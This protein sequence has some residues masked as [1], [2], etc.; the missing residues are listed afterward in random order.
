[1]P[2]FIASNAIS[3]FA[4]F[5]VVGYLRGRTA[6]KDYDG[7]A[8]RRPIVAPVLVIAFLSLVGIPPTVGFLG[9]LTLFMAPIN[10][11]YIW[12][13]VVAVANIVASLFYYARVMGSVYF[14]APPDEVAALDR[15]TGLV[16]LIGGFYVIGGAILAGSAF[17]AFQLSQLL[18]SRLLRLRG[19]NRQRELH[20]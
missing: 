13:A 15:S 14:N 8:K 5:A 18:P 2:A 11:G 16:M 7:L 19:L 20:P 6:L 3:N 10:G 9:K 12:L 1:L 4:A 17:T